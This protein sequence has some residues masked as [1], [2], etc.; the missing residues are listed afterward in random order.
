MADAYALLP[1]EAVGLNVQVDLGMKLGTL[2]HFMR[3]G[4]FARTVQDLITIPLP[5]AGQAMDVGEN[6]KKRILAWRSPTETLLIC[7]D[8]NLLDSLAHATASLNDGCIVDQRSGAWMFRA[9]GQAVPELVARLGGQMTMP[10]RGETRRSRLADVSVT[11]IK[12]QADEIL[13]VVERTY[14]A[15]LLAAIRACAQDLEVPM[16][17][18]RGTEAYCREKIS[19][20]QPT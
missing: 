6:S 8:D 11:A 4:V 13:L 10:A 14:G 7:G 9:S 16:F 18:S 2:R 15:H 17:D 19:R 1:V 3:N 5:A 20:N 12:V